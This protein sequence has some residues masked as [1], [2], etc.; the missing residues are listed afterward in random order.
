MKLVFADHEVY[1]FSKAFLKNLR[2]KKLAK[3]PISSEITRTESPQ[4]NR[5]GRPRRSS[6]GAVAEARAELLPHEGAAAVEHDLRNSRCRCRTP[7]SAA[8]AAP[9]VVRWR[10]PLGLLHA[11]QNHHVVQASRSGPVDAVEG[12]SRDLRIY[13]VVSKTRKRIGKRFQNSELHLT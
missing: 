12:V 8:A 6:L 2:I 4:N 13:S 7:L 5:R 3:I 1:Y 9:L 11:E 10:V